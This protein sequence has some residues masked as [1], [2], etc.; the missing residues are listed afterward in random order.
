MP[1]PILPALSL[2]DSELDVGDPDGTGVDL[3]N[4]N[5]VAYRT[6]AVYAYAVLDPKGL[7][8]LKEADES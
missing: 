8:V 7:A 6:E 1:I 4:V 2:A 3:Q 5:Q